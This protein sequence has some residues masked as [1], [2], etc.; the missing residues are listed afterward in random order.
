[1]SGTGQDGLVTDGGDDGTTRVRVLMRSLDPLVAQALELSY[2]RRLT[3]PEIAREFRMPR[4]S[5]SRMIATGLQEL[6][7]LLTIDT[8]TRVLRASWAPRPRLRASVP[9]TAR[10]TGSRTRRT[11]QP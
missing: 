11:N 4:E 1:M 6:A 8:P 2:F 10:P 3:Q 9:I 7:A 5:V